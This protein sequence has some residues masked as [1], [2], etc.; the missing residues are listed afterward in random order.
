MKFLINDM[1]KYLLLMATNRALNITRLSCFGIIIWTPRIVMTTMTR[2]E[3]SAAWELDTTEPLIMFTE[4]LSTL[5]TSGGLRRCSS[6][7][8]YRVADFFSVIP[9]FRLSCFTC[10][11]FSSFTC[12]LFFPGPLF[13]SSSFF[14][15]HCLFFYF[16]FFQGF[17]SRE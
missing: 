1:S 9:A 3:L 4:P 13:F 5:D 6:S 14:F 12:L 15:L 8:T 11:P 17:S 10:L 7:T 2:K 16:P